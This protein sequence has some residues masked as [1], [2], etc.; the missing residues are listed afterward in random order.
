MEEVAGHRRGDGPR[1]RKV[2][3][4]YFGGGTLVL[5]LLIVLRVL[6]LRGRA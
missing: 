4:V 3:P 6:V 2:T 1:P 5:I